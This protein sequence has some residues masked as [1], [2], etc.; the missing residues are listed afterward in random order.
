MIIRR[1]N[2][3][4]VRGDNTKMIEEI[5]NKLDED[6]IV[7]YEV[8]YSIPNDVISIRPDSKSF[9]VYIPSDLEYFQYEIDHFVKNMVPYNRS[10]IILERDIYKMD[11]RNPLTSNQYFKLVEFIISVTGFCT[12]L[13]LS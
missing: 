1:T 11:F 9:T 12:M 5:T 13:A 10:Q 2:S 6:R 7:D 8:S 3:P 4:F